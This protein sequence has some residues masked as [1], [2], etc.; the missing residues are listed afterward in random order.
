M[1][2]DYRVVKRDEGVSLFLALPGVPRDQLNVSVE[3]GLLTV[4]GKRPGQ[5]SEDWK[6][7]RA[8]R[9]PGTYKLTVRLHRDLDPGTV[10]ANLADGVLTL[11][12]ER[13]EAAKPK[14]IAVT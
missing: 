13:H 10:Q 9:A 5:A 3:Q 1:Q 8:L 4:T 2:P 12:L 6:C 14:V 11:T 7:H